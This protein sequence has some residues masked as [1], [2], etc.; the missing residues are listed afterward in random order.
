M[1]TMSPTIK[2]EARRWPYR[3]IRFWNADVLTNVDGLLEVKKILHPLPGPPP[4]HRMGEGNRPRSALAHKTT[5]QATTDQPVRYGHNLQTP[6]AS[7]KCSRIIDRLGRLSH[8]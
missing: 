8:Y 7:N 2:G 1:L 4:W 6:G 5:K 3:V